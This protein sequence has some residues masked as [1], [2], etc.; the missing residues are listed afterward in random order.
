MNSE[1]SC[2]EKYFLLF[3]YFVTTF[4]SCCCNTTVYLKFRAQM[5]VVLHYWP[6]LY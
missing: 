4:L 2:Y 1:K 5:A 3:F 6:A